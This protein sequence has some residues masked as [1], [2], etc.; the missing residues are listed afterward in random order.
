ME[1][2][3]IYQILIILNIISFILGYLV[4]SKKDSLTTTNNII[5]KRIIANSKNEDNIEYKKV[6]I[7]NSKIDIGT[8]TQGL[9]KKYNSLGN[10]KTTT[11]DTTSSVNKLKNLKR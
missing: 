5:K 7:D 6:K 2:T 11:D 10:V 4:K 8:N 1:K 9:E 3:I